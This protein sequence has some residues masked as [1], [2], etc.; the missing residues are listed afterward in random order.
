MIKYE[1]GDIVEVI[2][3]VTGHYFEIGDKVRVRSIFND[4]TIDSCEHLDKSDHWY[5]DNEEVRHIQG[6]LQ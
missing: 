2:D 3:N 5:V 6:E 1:V 4:G